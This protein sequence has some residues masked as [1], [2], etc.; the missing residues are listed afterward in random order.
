MYGDVNTLAAANNANN[1]VRNEI[2]FQNLIAVASNP[3]LF[4]ALDDQT[5]EKLV[6]MIASYTKACLL[7]MQEGLGNDDSVA[8]NFRAAIRAKNNR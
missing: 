1:L 2:S 3:T 4:N 8:V 6:L 7:A 5:K